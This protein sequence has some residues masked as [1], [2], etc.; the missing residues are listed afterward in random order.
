MAKNAILA[1][2]EAIGGV[3]LSSLSQIYREIFVDGKCLETL[4]LVPRAD[5]PVIVMLHQ[6]LGSLAAWKD[7]PEQLAIASGC[8][9]LVYSRYGHGKS[10][11]LREKRS[12]DYMHHE[13][14]VVL[15]QLLRQFQIEQPILLGHSDGGSIALIFAG[16]Q[17]AGGAG[18]EQVRALILEAPHV[19][20]EELSVQSIANTRVLYDS[21]D[22]PEK[23]G[24]YHDYPG[25]TFRGWNDIWL[26]PE[27]RRWNIEEYL[28]RI[29]CPVLVIQGKDDEHG[30]LAQVQAIQQQIPGTQTLILSDCGHSP[31]RDHPEV[32]LEAIAGFIA[33][34]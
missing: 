25:E 26:D 3:G 7:F 32:T 1:R 27:F 9:V 5:A 13:A 34:L 29:T 30:T 14:K 19:F 23:L 8:R 21:T 2:L 10:E 6:G 18:G 11:R 17:A 4:Q 15:P 20:V 12:V 16:S 22:L 31:H 33:R 28:A 24:R